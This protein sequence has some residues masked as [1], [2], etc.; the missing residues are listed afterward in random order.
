MNSSF[1]EASSAARHREREL[2]RPS[3]S[4]RSLVLP[5]LVEPS[6]PGLCISLEADPFVLLSARPRENGLQPSASASSRTLSVRGRQC[7]RIFPRPVTGNWATGRALSWP[8]RHPYVPLTS[9][10]TRSPGSRIHGRN[11]ILGQP[12]TLPRDPCSSRARARTRGSGSRKAG[13]SPGAC[14]NLIRGDLSFRHLQG[15]PYGRGRASTRPQTP[16]RAPSDPTCG[17]WAPA[18]EEPQT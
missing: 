17:R 13:G 8:C 18:L 2:W 6:I 3:S 12:V 1:G 7:R 9:S 15:R 5:S 16:T 14:A 4:A 11:S 10:D